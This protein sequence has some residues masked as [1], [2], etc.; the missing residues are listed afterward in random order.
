M[1][2]GRRHIPRVIMRPQFTHPFAVPTPP[3]LVTGVANGAVRLA[4]Q[5]EYMS[6]S[7]SGGLSCHVQAVIILPM[8][9]G[10]IAE[11]RLDSLC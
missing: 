9:G 2:K 10:G 1:R 6:P 3:F 8:C 5:A 4:C 7:P 11:P